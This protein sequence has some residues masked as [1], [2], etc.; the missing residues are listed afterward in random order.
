MEKVAERCMYTLIGKFTHAM[1]KM[2]N[3]R[4]EFLLQ[5]QLKGGVKLTYFNSRHLC[6]ELD[7]AYDHATIWSKGK[8]YLQ[9]QLM[10][11]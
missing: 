10:K 8:I 11:I 6:I 3:I 9:G 2:D 1:L 5:T 4:R 7:N